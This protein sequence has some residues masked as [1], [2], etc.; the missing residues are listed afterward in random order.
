[1]SL[2]RTDVR[3]AGKAAAVLDVIRRDSGGTVPADVIG[4]LKRL[5]ALLLSS[6]VP[7]SM[8]FLYSKAG[9]RS[10]LEQ[11]YAAI[12]D[13][14]RAEL[15][16]VWGWSDRPGPLQ[17]FTRVSDPAQVDSA[18]LSR[19]SVRLGEFA[20]WLRRLAEAIEHS[21]PVPGS[22]ARSGA[23]AQAQGGPGA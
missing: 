19:A 14:L 4:Q 1:M 2:E 12:L 16:A 7:A 5:P 8:A 21:E 20:L 18:A 13:A 6:G 11:A 23:T 10:S 17:F 15:A 9:D 22:G 3:L